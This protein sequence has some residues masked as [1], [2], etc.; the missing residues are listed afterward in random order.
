M[1]RY[2]QVNPTMTCC[3]LS[4]DKKR[5]FS[6]KGDSGA[7]VWTLDG[8]IAGLISGGT[9]N[10]LVPRVDITYMDA[11]EWILDDLRTE[12]PNAHLL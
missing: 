5:I 3:I 9:N 6:D 2:G 10:S 8:R 12:F 1:L 11:I 4:L 7:C